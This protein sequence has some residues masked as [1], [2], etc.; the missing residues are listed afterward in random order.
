[1]L[2]NIYLTR[3]VFSSGKVDHGHT[4]LKGVGLGSVGKHLH[5]L[6]Q[7]GVAALLGVQRRL[8]RAAMAVQVVQLGVPDGHARQLLVKGQAQLVAKVGSVVHLQPHVVVVGQLQ[9]AF[10]AHVVAF[11]LD[12]LLFNLVE[13]ETLTIGS[14]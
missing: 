11:N 12:H 13:E 2:G 1:V 3:A 6:A 10:A 9:G 5:H 7:Q 8:G 14:P 4:L